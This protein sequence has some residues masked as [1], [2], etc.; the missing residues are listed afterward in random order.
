M[1]ND[2]GQIDMLIK[3]DE[4][5][6]KRAFIDGANA[7]A[8]IL[9][10]AMGGG[11]VPAGGGGTPGG[12]GGPTIVPITPPR[13]PGGPGVPGRPLP[14]PRGAGAAS[15]TRLL[16][17]WGVAIGVV[18]GGLYAANKGLKAV[19]RS[20][21]E[22]SQRLARVSGPVAMAE[23]MSRIRDIQRDIQSA[24]RIGPSLVRFRAALDSARDA[25]Q[26]VID[27]IKI[28]LYGV[29]TTLIRL[30]DAMGRVMRIVVNITDRM[31]VAMAN[32]LLVALEWLALFNPTASVG[33]G[34][35]AQG[36]REIH[37]DLKERLRLERMRQ[38]VNGAAQSNRAFERDVQALTGAQ[39]ADDVMI[40]EGVFKGF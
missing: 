32:I 35:I 30:F 4:G 10:R 6:I 14:V 9:R 17:P 27:S 8:A 34:V 5:Q 20:A 13:T 25:W 18:V 26:P 19:A 23:A 12:G 37:D 7:A 11:A 21:M 3:A 38:G 22:T 1:A 2:I 33:I 39:W 16:G 40:R 31:V 15:V 29:V 36:I 28:R 24:Q